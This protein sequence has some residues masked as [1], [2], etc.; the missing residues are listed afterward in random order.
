MSRSGVAGAKR[1]RVLQL[2][3]LKHVSDAGL[4]EIASVMSTTRE[5]T[6]DVTKWR[7]EKTALDEYD[8]F[9]TSIDIPLEGDT[10]FKWHL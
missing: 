10:T 3:G 4:C 9:G 2:V 5:H 6:E 1:Q 7:V 8:K